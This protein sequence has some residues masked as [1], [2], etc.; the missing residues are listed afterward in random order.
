MLVL[1]QH[2]DL[3]VQFRMSLNFLLAMAGQELPYCTVDPK[4]V[5]A[6]EVLSKVN[7]IVARLP[8]PGVPA[9]GDFAVVESITQ[10]GYD[11][12]KRMV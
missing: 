7:L 1:A 6:I 2:V 3:G 8:E 9:P 4:E 10:P 5:L 12:I 11:L